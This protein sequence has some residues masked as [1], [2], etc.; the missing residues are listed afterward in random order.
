M[1]T[2]ATTTAIATDRT[3][4]SMTSGHLLSHSL[5]REVK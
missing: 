3:T 1:A 4:I 2:V 5:L